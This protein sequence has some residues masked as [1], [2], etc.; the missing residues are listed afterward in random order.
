[1]IPPGDSAATIYYGDEVAGQPVITAA[2]AGV[3][4]GTQT[5]T[6]TAGQAAGLTSPTPPPATAGAAPRP[7]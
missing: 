6:V 7:R 5:E 3:S 4:P 1:M 2:A